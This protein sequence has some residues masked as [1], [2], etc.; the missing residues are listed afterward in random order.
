L[1]FDIANEQIADN[2]LIACKGRIFKEVELYR[3][4]YQIFSSREAGL[5][6]WF[7]V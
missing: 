6:N 5:I 7:I 1:I 2:C 3:F 4:N